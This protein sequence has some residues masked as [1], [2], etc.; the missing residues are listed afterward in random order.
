[1]ASALHISACWRDSGSKRTNKHLILFLGRR[2]DSLHVNTRTN[3]N[4]RSL[5]LAIYEKLFC[6]GD[7]LEVSCPEKKRMSCSGT[8]QIV[9]AGGFDSDTQV[10]VLGKFDASLERVRSRHGAGE[11]NRKPEYD[12]RQS[13]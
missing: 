11:K 1:M 8:A 7:I 12:E 2:V 6:K 5:V 3:G 9:M 13:H 10:I 4:Y